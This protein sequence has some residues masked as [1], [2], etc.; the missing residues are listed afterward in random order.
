MCVYGVCWLL[1]LDTKR[2]YRNSPVMSCLVLHLII[3]CLTT[4]PLRY[5]WHFLASSCQR[6]RVLLLMVLLPLKPPS[7]SLRVSESPPTQLK[8]RLGST[9]HNLI[10]HLPVSFI[11]TDAFMN[12]SVIAIIEPKY[13]INTVNE[14]LILRFV[15]SAGSYSPISP[16]PLI[17]AILFVYTF[18]E[19]VALD[20]SCRV[21]TT[22][23]ECVYELEQEL[24]YAYV[25]ENEHL[26]DKGPKL[27]KDFIAY[28]THK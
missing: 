5:A 9:R 7:P 12:A 26:L 20:I 11:A 10:R 24:N 19:A 8:T 13:D 17:H 21:W 14:Y 23:F 15:A 1:V 25:N 2:F 22:V 18:N 16:L 3:L 6:E 27:S 28:C 4:K